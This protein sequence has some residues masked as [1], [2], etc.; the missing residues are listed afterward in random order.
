MIIAL[1]VAIIA[2]LLLT[3]GK[4]KIQTCISLP[5][6]AFYI[7]FAATITIIARNTSLYT[8]YNLMPFWTYR[9]VLE[10]RTDLL[11]EILWNVVLF[12]PIGLLLMLLLTCKKRWLISIAIGVFLSS[13]IEVIQLIFHRGLFEFDDIFH[14]TLGT[15]IGIGIYVVAARLI[16]KFKI[17]NKPKTAI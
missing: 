7:S 4:I 15:L 12:V 13:A 1:L 14:N 6:L 5:L 2:G 9:A 3:F 11:S 8:K 10:G 16:S 17:K